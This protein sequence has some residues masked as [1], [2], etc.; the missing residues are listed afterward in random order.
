MRFVN[1]LFLP[2]LVFSTNALKICLLKYVHLFND[3]DNAVLFDAGVVLTCS[4][5]Y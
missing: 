3:E 4:N 5:L 1:Y 2:A